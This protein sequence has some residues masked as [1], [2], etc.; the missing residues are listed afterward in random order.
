MV[1]PSAFLLYIINILRIFAMIKKLFE[2]PLN[3]KHLFTENCN[4]LQQFVT[5]RNHF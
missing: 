1:L 5:V 2:D 3:P 4:K